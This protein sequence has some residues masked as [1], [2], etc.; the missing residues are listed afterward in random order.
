MKS[1]LMVLALVMCCAHAAAAQDAA[2][3]GKAIAEEKCARCHAIGKTGTSPLAQAPLFRDVV[4]RYPVDNLAEALAE[5]I[6]VGH[7]AMPEFELSPEQIAD[8]LNY[9]A[10]LQQ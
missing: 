1:A 3:A 8:L 6:T 2:G 7:E 5:G 9:L 10:T 4:K